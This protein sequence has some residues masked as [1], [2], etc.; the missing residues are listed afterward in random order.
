[1]YSKCS[2]RIKCNNLMSKLMKSSTGLMQGCPL[3]PTLSNIFQ[4]DLHS[5]FDHDCCPINIGKYNL[6]SLS[7]ADDLVLVS[8]TPEGLQN[9][10]DKLNDYCNKWNLT[11][12]VDK[13]KSMVFG[14]A[15]LNNLFF[16]QKK[17][18]QTDF[19]T[20]LGVRIHKSGKIK[21]SILDRIEKHPEQ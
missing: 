19:Y 6:N 12:N 9:C 10:L 20:Y 13:T 16:R 7:W 11:V 1:M 18:I 17:I 21:Y 4:N 3:S 5:I 15:K 8:S 14:K 2:Y